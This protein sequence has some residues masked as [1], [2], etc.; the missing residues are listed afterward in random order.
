MRLLLLA[1]S[2][3]VLAQFDYDRTAPLAA[4]PEPLAERRSARMWGGSFGAGRTNF[5]LVEPKQRGR[6]PGVLFQHGGGQ[7]MSNYIS[8]ALILAELGVTSLIVDAAGAN[9]RESVVELVVTE[10]R[11]LDLLLRQAG[12]DPKRIGYVGHSYGGYAGGVLAGVDPRITAYVLIGA[13]PSLAQHIR[14][15]PAAHWAPIRARPD[16]DRVLSGIA[17]VDA[18][19]FLPHAKSPVF[20]KCAKF[21]TPDNVRA[22]PEVHR[23]A[24][25]PKSLTWYQ[26]D[27]NFTSFEATR[28]RLSWLTKELKLSGMEKVLTRWAKPKTGE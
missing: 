28:D 27:H 26:D 5:V 19:Q 10:R 4:R 23:L 12:V 2:L 18:E 9:S 1:C 3:P 22:C 11:A 16:L 8:E 25:G 14:E 17:E 13:I 15:S 20:V 7:S 21:D 6:H 24:G